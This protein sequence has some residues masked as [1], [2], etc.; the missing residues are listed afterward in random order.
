MASLRQRNGTYRFPSIIWPAND[1]NHL[2][3][4]GGMAFALIRV[5]RGQPL[6]C[7]GPTVRPSIGW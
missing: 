3:N 4:A 5:I 2:T 7:L 6:S 1:A